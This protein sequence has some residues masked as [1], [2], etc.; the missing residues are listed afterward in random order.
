M[1]SSLNLSCAVAVL[2]AMGAGATPALAQAD[3]TT[4]ASDASS[5]LDTGEIIVTATRREETANRIPVAI[6][7]LSGESLQKLNITNFE[8]LVEYLPNVRTASRGPGISSIYIRGL[9]TD[10]AGS[11]ILGVAGVQPNVALYIND[12]PASTP[13]R[14]DSTAVGSVTIRDSTSV[15]PRAAGKIE[16]TSPT[17]VSRSAARSP[18]S[19]PRDALITTWQ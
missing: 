4:A 13:G 9:S 8:K 18:P 3:K 6:Q 1:K 12:A 14:T 17:T 19:R 2:V 10:T 15:A 11:Q 7:A 5:A 16:R